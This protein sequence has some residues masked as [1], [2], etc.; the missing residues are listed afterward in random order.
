YRVA[1]TV[2]LMMVHVMGVS[3]D[4]A[5]KNAASLGIAMQLT[6]IAR[7]VME[8]AAM[9]RV[10]LPGV[11]L[12]EAGVPRE[13]VADRRFRPLVTQVVSRLV[14]SAEG[15]YREGNEGIKYLPLRAA[16][17]VAMASRIYSRIGKL[18]K[19]RGARAWENRCMV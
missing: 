16:L 15:Y 1:G 3:D 2:G 6:N 7:D 13:S 14:K 5:L 18:V 4:K 19:K 8:D 9:D 17:A 10:Y 12:E 11:W